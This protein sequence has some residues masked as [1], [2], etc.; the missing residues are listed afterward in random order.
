MNKKIEKIIIDEV[1]S[2]LS[3]VDFDSMFDKK[4]IKKIIDEEISREITSKVA[5]HIDLKIMKGIQKHIP[6]L[7]YFVAEKVDKIIR[8][9]KNIK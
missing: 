1:I 3:E 9:V 8:E 7:D 4:R 2:S 5:Q 6:V